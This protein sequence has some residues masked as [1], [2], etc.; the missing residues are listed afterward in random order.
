MLA[1]RDMSAHQ[2]PSAVPPVPARVLAVDDQ[3]GFRAIMRRLVE[4]AHGLDLV[5]EANCGEDAIVAAA[6]F[7]PDMVVMDVVM[8]GTDGIDAARRIKSQR[9]ATVIVLVSTT[10]PDDLPPEA[11]G[12]HVDAI[13][14]KPDLRPSLLESIWR[15]YAP[16]A[17]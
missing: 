1:E 17:G 4:A 13:V 8:P 15:R 9:A 10:H 2:K 14:W 5:A 16:L 12:L 3:E 11:A 6:E 7:E